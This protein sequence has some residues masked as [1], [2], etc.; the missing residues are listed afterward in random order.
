MRPLYGRALGQER[1]F[2]S[3]PFRRTKNMTIIGAIDYEKVMAATYGQWAANGE[4][5]LQFLEQQLCPKLKPHHVVIMD[6]VRFHQVTGVR[7]L[8]EATGARLI[9]LPPYHPELNP[10]ENM[11]SKIKNSLRTSSSRTN[12]TFKKA[13]RVAF[14]NIHDSDLQGWFKH[15]G[16]LDQF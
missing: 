15:A 12:R 5:F 6:N 9:Y 8:I 3:S 4:I 10:I 11:W 1:A 16:Y 2:L 14:E 7:D 13:I